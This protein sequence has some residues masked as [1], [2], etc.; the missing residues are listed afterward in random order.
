MGNNASQEFN[1][2]TK[3][4]EIVAK[5][6]LTDKVIIVTGG[7]AGIG[8]ETVRVLAK[9]MLPLFSLVEILLKGTQ[10]YKK[11]KSKFQIHLKLK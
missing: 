3:A 1:K 2:K 8:T 6:D 7:S 4:E 11:F 9:K 10:F 5:L